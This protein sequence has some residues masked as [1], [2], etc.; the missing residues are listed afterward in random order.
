MILEKM[1]YLHDMIREGVKK[2]FFYPSTHPRVF[3]RFGRR[4]G[5]IRVEKGYFRGDLGRFWGVWTLFG[6]QP[7]HP[8]TFG[9][10]LQKNICFTPSLKELDALE[11]EAGVLRRI[12]FKLLSQV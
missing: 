6:H 5:E 8:P 2:T 11:V 9:R 7:P 10:N 12:L 3:V 1:L 4:K